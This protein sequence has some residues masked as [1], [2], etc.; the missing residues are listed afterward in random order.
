MSF[1]ILRACYVCVGCATI[2]VSVQ[3]WHSQLTLNARNIPSAAVDRLLR[4]SK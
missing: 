2:E 1:G 4:M 3:S